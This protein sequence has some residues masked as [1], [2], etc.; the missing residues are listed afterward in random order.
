MFG[1]M[2]FQNTGESLQCVTDLL[3]EVK[4]SDESGTGFTMRATVYAAALALKQVE[5]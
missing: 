1:V 4:S 5:I 2:L 3:K